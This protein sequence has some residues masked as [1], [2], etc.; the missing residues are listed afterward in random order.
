MENSLWSFGCS[1]TADWYI[2]GDDNPNNYE[3]YR[4][5]KGGTLP[6]VW[7]T[8]LANKLDYKNQNK[9]K[10]ATSNYEIFYSFC[11]SVS[12][13]RK[14]DIVIFQWTSTYRFLLADDQHFLQTVLPSVKY[15][16]FEQ[17]LIDKILVNRTNEVWIS[18]L[19]YF[20]KIINEIC[21]EKNVHIFYWSYHDDIINS[22]MET[23]WDE[24]P[25]DKYIKAKG[26]NRLLEYL[27]DT[28]NGNHTIYSETNGQVKDAHLGEYGHISQ[29]DLFYN[30]IKQII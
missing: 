21:K 20:S 18:E 5:L 8:I 16:N 6:P 7:P 3:L 28:C 13:F 29:S 17:E 4:V 30:Y 2:K 12:K 11:D 25:H 24:F 10:G 1:F 14:N 26:Y 9:G 22:Y 19:I 15:S 23:S 27:K